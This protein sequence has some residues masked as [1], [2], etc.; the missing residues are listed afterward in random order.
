MSFP[1]ASSITLSPNIWTAVAK[2]TSGESKVVRDI[3]Q[4]LRPAFSRCWN[5]VTPPHVTVKSPD[6]RFQWPHNV[7][8]NKRS[9]V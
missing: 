5:A 4:N 1:Y 6:E 9:I 2:G 7:L 3:R 8:F